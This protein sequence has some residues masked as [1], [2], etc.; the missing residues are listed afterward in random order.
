MP[1]KLPHYGEQVPEDEFRQDLYPN[2]YGGMNVGLASEHG[3]EDSISAYDLKQAHDWLR[4]YR[5]DE[6]KAIPVLRQ[7]TQLEQGAIYIDLAAPRREEFKAL[8]NM[9]ADQGRA[10]VPKSQVDYPLWN[11]LIGVTNPERLNQADER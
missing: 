3:D 10:L 6:L 5:D 11:R 8:G 9:T 2:S 7:G 4:D 1:H